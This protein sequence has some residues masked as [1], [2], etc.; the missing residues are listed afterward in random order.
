MTVHRTECPDDV[1]WTTVNVSEALPGVVTPLTWSFFGDAADEAFKG[2]FCDL[3]VLPPSRVR[4]GERAE[5]RLWDIF[6]GRVA[7]NLN[8]FRALADRMPGTSGDAIEE[9]LFGHVRPGV[10][11][12]PHYGRYPV[13]AA[14]MPYAAVRLPRRL[15]RVSAEARLLWERTTGPGALP[16]ADT[17]R[18]ALAHAYR[19]FR[20]VL[21][22]HLLAAMLCQSL[23]EQL[24][25]L[26]GHAGLPG[27]ELSLATGYGDMAETTVVAD[28]WEVSRYRLDLDTFIARHGFHGPAEGELSA[29]VWRIRREPL[30]ALV[31]SY[32]QMDESRAPRQLERER[33]AERAR[34][35]AELLAN[36]PTARRAVAPLIL[37]AAARY[38]P[39]RGIGKAAFLQCLDVA[40]NAAGV[41][42]IQL[43]SQGLLD[44]PG[45]V[46]WLTVDEL[47]P[48]KPA[49]GLLESARQRRAAH[50]EYQRMEVPGL[51]QGMP[52][53]QP[54]TAVSDDMTT[55][56]GAAVS[57]GVVEGIARLILD[58]A[59]DEPVDVGE[60]LV[61]RTTDP[62]W[63][64]IML[65]AGG[66]VIDIGGPISHGAVIAREL[67]VPCVIGTENGTA[68]IRT[69]DRVR[70]DGAR[71]TVEILERNTP[72]VVA[73]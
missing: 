66:M 32:R 26:A 58:P 3:G 61:C 38:I 67:G 13:V 10:N 49:A 28:L 20:T 35:S 4:P 71:G 43:T 62:S 31:D 47:L 48:P 21:R 2:V 9:Q 14:K 7:V 24:R 11:S 54:L 37:G 6:Y 59:E 30:V 64:S 39:L 52:E 19:Q 36:L 25:L 22:P 65:V 68:R 1:A 5:D 44:E 42:G 51:W 27:L 41:L 29:K 57:P 55:V 70:V 34:A 69:G 46:F 17:A 72:E 63:A 40:R 18:V 50:Q 16:S 15:G 60:I 45:H 23:Y 53:P 8:M 73:H 33:A 56:T 12:E